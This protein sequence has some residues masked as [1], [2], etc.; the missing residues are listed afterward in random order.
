MIRQDLEEINANY[1]ELV[2]VSEEAVKRRK[3]SQQVN[4]ELLE[5]NQKL[6]DILSAMEEELVRIQK[7]SEVLDGLTILAEVA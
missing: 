6:Q 3:M 2:Q 4:L 1:A 5:Q 7:R